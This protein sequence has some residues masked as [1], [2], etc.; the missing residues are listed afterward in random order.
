MAAIFVGISGW[1]FEG[2]RGTFYPDGLKQKD[3]LSYASRRVRSIEVNGT[4]YSL[5]R[6]SAYE[7]WYEQSP[8]DFTFAIKAPKYITHERRLDGFETPLANFLASGILRLGEKLGPILW[9]FPPSMPF[10]PELFESFMKAL[11]HDMETAAKLGVGHSDWMAGRTY[12]DVTTNHRMRHAIEG[13]HK[14]F[15]SPAFV[16]MARRYGIA[17]VVGDTAGRWPYIEDVCTDFIYLRLHADEKKYPN[18]YGKD[19]LERWSSRFQAWANG[20]QPDDA[21]LVIPGHPEKMPR[22]VFAYFD[23]DV[24]ETAPLNAL[25]AISHLLQAEAIEVREFAD[26]PKIAAAKAPRKVEASKTS[27][28]EKDVGAARRVRKKAEAAAV[29]KSSK[30]TTKDKASTA[31][32]AKKKTKAEGKVKTTKRGSA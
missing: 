1:N 16:E 3:E 7:N 29:K 30:T 27:A 10:D 14:S 22:Q 24:K 13:R 21:A 28:A 2:W 5:F 26:L 31:S 15:Q 6:P 25:S 9:Q 4:F 18:G 8:A 23:N 11:P 17:I 19:D 20:M 32:T 12:L